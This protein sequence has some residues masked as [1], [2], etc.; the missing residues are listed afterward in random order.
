VTIAE[1]IVDI[2]LGESD[3]SD[4]SMA[5][6]IVK[7]VAHDLSMRE[8]GSLNAEFQFGFAI[9]T[10]SEDIITS[11]LQEQG[12]DVSSVYWEDFNSGL[13][14]LE[15]NLI[16]ILREDAGLMLSPEGHDK[17]GDYIGTGWLHFER[18]KK[19]NKPGVELLKLAVEHDEPFRTSSGTIN[20]VP[21]IEKMYEG[22][23]DV[24]AKGADV[25]ISFFG[26][27]AIRRFFEE[28]E[29]HP[30]A[31]AY[32]RAVQTKPVAEDTAKNIL[33]VVSGL[34]QAAGVHMKHVD[35]V[36]I[37]SVRCPG[38]HRIHGEFRTFD[39]ASSNKQCKFCTRDFVDNFKKVTDTGNFKH[40]LKR[41]HD[42]R[43]NRRNR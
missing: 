34:D 43:P 42:K 37:Y 40:L 35:G 31:V 1:T 20:R 23:P 10:G 17:D 9:S 13:T 2:L 38:C 8:L 21:G 14:K 5:R 7:R 32:A 25:T 19:F 41:R 3:D 22:V 18:D 29:N 27:E 15:N 39:E 33:R 36:P 30:A 12:I 11:N 4:D 24:V 6:D 16:W 28:L 26:I